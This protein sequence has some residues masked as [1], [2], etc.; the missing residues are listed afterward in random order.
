MKLYGAV[1]IKELSDFRKQAE[2]LVEL[3][4]ELR[5]EQEELQPPVRIV[6]TRK[7]ARSER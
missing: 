4:D 6:R 2:R 3:V 5:T 7:T 1:M